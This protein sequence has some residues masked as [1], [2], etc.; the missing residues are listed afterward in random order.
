MWARKHRVALILGGA[1][2]ALVLVLGLGTT[3]WSPLYQRFMPHEQ[4]A[5]ALRYLDKLAAGDVDDIYAMLDPAAVTPQSKA[6]LTDASRLLSQEKRVRAVE[7]GGTVNVTPEG[8]FYNITFQFEYP[9][10]TL[11]SNLYFKNVAG[12]G[13]DIAALHALPITEPLDRANK[14]TLIRKPAIDYA[15]LVALIVIVIFT[16]YTLLCLMDTPIHDRK[17]LWIV[18]CSSASRLST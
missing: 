11:I 1:F 2:L 18:S 8:S 12:G 17:W 13:I 7:V 14:F 5:I 10:R 9:K 15:V 4:A 3:D 6:A 16:L